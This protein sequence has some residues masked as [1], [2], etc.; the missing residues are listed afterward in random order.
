MIKEMVELTI[1]RRKELLLEEIYNAEGLRDDY[2]RKAIYL[3]EELDELELDVNVGV[4]E[5]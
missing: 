3:Q 5:Q 2:D 1:E 4:G